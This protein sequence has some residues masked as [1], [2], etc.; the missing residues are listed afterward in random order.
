[1]F[2]FKIIRFRTGLLE[3]QHEITGRKRPVLDCQEG[4]NSGDEG[5]DWVVNN[6]TCTEYTRRLDSY[7]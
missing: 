5:C 3:Q 2:L 4:G 7:L 6:H 1:M